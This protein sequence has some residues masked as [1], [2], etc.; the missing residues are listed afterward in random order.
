MN[1]AEKKAV[2]EV[3]RCLKKYQGRY[4]DAS[5]AAKDYADSAAALKAL[6]ALLVNEN[7]ITVPEGK[8]ETGLLRLKHAWRNPFVCRQRWGSYP[9][10]RMLANLLGA[11]VLAHTGVPEEY[12]YERT[13]R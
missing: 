8:I 5:H 10:P 2:A 11:L 3:V 12:I 4:H 13:R 6:D 7:E 1:D 9:P